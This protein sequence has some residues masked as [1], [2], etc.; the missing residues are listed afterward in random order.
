MADL[1]WNRAFAFEQSGEDEEI[2]AELL[3]LFRESTA[4]DLEKIKSGI[5]A[6]DAK[7][8]GEAAH[9]IKGAAASLGIEAMSKVAY[10][11]EKA[12]R[13]NDLEVAIK[14]LPELEALAGELESLK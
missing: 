2:L 10:E 6:Q 12:G 8:V 9:S 3:D 1:E 14:H 5:S 7:A 11:M 13:K 4:A